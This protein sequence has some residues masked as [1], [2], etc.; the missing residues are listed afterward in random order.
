MC[1]NFRR[2]SEGRRALETPRHTREDNI[3]MALRELGW[4]VVNWMDLAQ[5]RG[6]WRTFVNTVM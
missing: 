3:R 4:G 1:Q 2:K 5:D 6:Q